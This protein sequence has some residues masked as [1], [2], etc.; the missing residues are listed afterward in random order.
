[1]EGRTCAREVGGGRTCGQRSRGIWASKSW[2]V[3]GGVERWRGF[4][5]EPL[6]VTDNERRDPS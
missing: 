2:L 3:I 5:M 6:F 4:E 1:M